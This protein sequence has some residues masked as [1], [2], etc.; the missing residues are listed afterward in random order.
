M[1]DMA[2]EIDALL[3]AYEPNYERVARLGPTA[4]PVLRRLSRDPDLLMASRAIHA[5]GLIGGTDGA[6]IV[7]RAARSDEVILRAAAAG[8]L[9]R[10]EGS[11]AEPLL[12]AL[13]DDD[14]PSIRMAATES[15]A[16]FRS[17]ELIDR[18]A[19]ISRSDPEPM[20][21]G[22]AEGTIGPMRED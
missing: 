22:A 20:V 13:L 1:T 17:K 16:A 6:E 2:R 4:V 21:R 11:V 14:D 5:A 12:L 10:M 19:T 7:E 18:V 3:S 15:A 8:T 9:A